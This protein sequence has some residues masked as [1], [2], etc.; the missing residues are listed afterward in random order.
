MSRSEKRSSLSSPLPLPPPPPP[1]KS[2]DLADRLS[3]TGKDIL[4]K[5]FM[6]YEDKLSKLTRS[7]GASEGGRGGGGGG[8]KGKRTT[9]PGAKR[10]SP[11]PEGGTGSE[12]E[13][14]EGDENR[15]KRPRTGR[16]YV[17]QML[18]CYHNQNTLVG[19]KEGLSPLHLLFLQVR[20]LSSCCLF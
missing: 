4:S 11:P 10:G 15:R 17:V 18:S 6:G 20:L 14:G 9:P 13:A 5:P 12:G 2:R 8:G 1:R 19:R 7:G 3:P 16:K